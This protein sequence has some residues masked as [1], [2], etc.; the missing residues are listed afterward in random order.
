MLSRQAND[1]LRDIYLNFREDFLRLFP[2]F[3]END[4]ERTFLR[5]VALKAA[6]DSDPFLKEVWDR[7]DH[8]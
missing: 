7:I 6:G 1:I 8:L 5:V 4:I 2:G 3:N